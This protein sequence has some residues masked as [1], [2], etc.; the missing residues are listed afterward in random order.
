MTVYKKGKKVSLYSKNGR[1][2]VERIASIV[3]SQIN[4]KNIKAAKKTLKEYS[5]AVDTIY[6]EQ[7]QRIKD[8]NDKI[9]KIESSENEIDQYKKKLLED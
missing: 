2:S 8:F 3:K 7:K 4:D 1:I 5:N 6:N 9:K